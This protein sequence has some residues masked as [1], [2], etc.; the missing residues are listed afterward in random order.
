[1]GG[2]VGQWVEELT[3]AVLEHRAA[4]FIYLVAPGD[5]ISDTTLNLW[6]HEVV[7]A[8]RQQI[9]EELK[10]THR[11]GG[12]RFA[13]VPEP[14][15]AIQTAEKSNKGFDNPDRPRHTRRR[16]PGDLPVHRPVTRPTVI[17]E[18]K[19]GPPIVGKVNARARE[20]APAGRSRAQACR[21]GG[22]VR[23]RI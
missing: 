9:R 22:P 3:F 19:P 15:Q 16:R 17:V 12:Q 1:M 2:A 18:S 10:G 5:T 6:A 11:F 8:V 4:A 7:P 20:R 23:A 21:Q 13:T 14:N